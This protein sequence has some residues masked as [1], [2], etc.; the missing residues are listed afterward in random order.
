MM[1]PVVRLADVAR[2]AGVSQGTASNAFNRPDI[3]RPEL[4]AKVE[5]AALSLGYAGPDPKGRL[6]RAGKVHALGVVVNNSLGYFFNDPFNREFMRGVAAVCDAEGAGLSLI[7]SHDQK[8]AA[9]SIES[10]VVDGFILQC[11]EG[12]N[13]LVEL[14]RKRRLPFVAVDL[15]PGTDAGSIIVDERGGAQAAAEH[16]LGLGHRR[17]AILTLPLIDDGRTGPVDRSRRDATQYNTT[18]ERLAGYAEALSAA[19]IAIDSV[20]IVESLNDRR[21][22]EGARMVL[23]A[24]PEATAI[25]AMSD[26]LAL[27]VLAEAVRRG[28]RVPQHLSVVGFDDV[29]EAAAS[30]PAL[31]TVH[32]PIMEK[33]RIAAGMILS[34]ATERVALRTALAVRDS[35]APPPETLR[36]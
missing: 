36:R 24:A 33:G 17:F 14:A 22:E 26:V 6:L 5:A 31:T 8:S 20:P 27:A 3:V 25:L 32:Q 2:A 29:P 11:L 13:R 1:K 16:L 21:A 28:R 4:R 10:A 9:W 23:D 35:T 30:R 7:A 19:G 15:Y 12:G 34:G 18:R